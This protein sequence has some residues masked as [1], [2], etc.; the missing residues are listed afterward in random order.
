[1]PEC[2]TR[3][4]LRGYGLEQARQNGVPEGM[5]DRQ[6]KQESDWQHCRPDGSLKV[7]SGNAV[8]VAQI[9]QR[10]HPNVD[11]TDPWAS[12]RY[13][14]K[15][16][17]QH[18]DRFGS[19]K[20][21]LAAYNW[22]GS[23]V[24]GYTK[25]DGSV[26]PP[27]DGRRE[28]IS[29]QG[30][31]YLDVILGPGWPEPVENM[32]ESM[33]GIV[34]ENFRDPA[35][36]GRFTSVPKGVILHGS[37]SG[38]AGNPKDVEYLGTARYEQN[39]PDL[40]WHATVGENK[41]AVHLTPYEWGWNARDASQ[42]YIAVEIAQAT[43][44]EEITDAQCA[45]LA[46]YLKTRIFPVWGDLGFHFPTHAELEAWGE[47][48]QKDGKTDVFP[49]GDPRVDG[50]RNRLYALL[51]APGWEQPSPPPP[52]PEPPPTD[53]RAELR[54]VLDENNAAAIEDLRGRLQALLGSV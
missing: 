25:P 22:G 43:V 28:T 39:N 5:Y 1:M 14:A 48:G 42:F 34:Y 36:A 17:R 24:S 53:L 37:R 52:S 32:P 47:T 29:A 15:L 6:V 9:I 2:P 20:K 26:V 38:K 40:G 8:G 41:V 54:R 21:A 19:W 18:F 45:A 44:D 11:V 16:M 7:S 46:D 13:S 3:D 23:N 35:P 30:A 33:P 10:W 27:W 4:E 51:G 12:L 31:H 49:L 50:V